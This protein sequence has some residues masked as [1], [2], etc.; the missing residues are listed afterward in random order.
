[1]A[2]RQSVDPARAVQAFADAAVAQ[3]ALP[4]LAFDLR[5][6]GAPPR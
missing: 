6:F 3:G 4:I 2:L 5:R 1:V